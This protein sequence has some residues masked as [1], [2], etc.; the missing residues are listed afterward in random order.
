MG[1]YLDDDD[2]LR[3]MRDRFMQSDPGG[4]AM[5]GNAYGAPPRELNPA[6]V[7]SFLA[8]KPADDRGPYPIPQRESG[9][10][11]ADWFPLAAAGLDLAF[12]KGR[13]MGGIAQSAAGMAQ[14][15]D[16]LSQQQFEDDRN[17]YMKQGEAGARDRQIDLAGRNADMRQMEIDAQLAKEKAIQARWLGER[18]D[19]E[20]EKQAKEAL[21]R[22]SNARATQ[23]EADAARDPNAIT[24]YQQAQL[25]AQKSARQLTDE[26]RDAARAD[27]TTALKMQ[28]DERSEARTFR[29]GQTKRQNDVDAQARTQKLG[30][31]FA[32]QYEYELKALPALMTAQRLVDEV[33]QGGDIPG[34]GKWDSVK[35]SIPLIGAQLSSDKDLSMRSASEWMANIVQRAESGAAAPVPEALGYRIRQGSQPGATER[36]FKLGLAAA[37]EY[38]R[39]TLRAGSYGREDAARGVTDL[40]SRGGGDFVFGPVAQPPTNPTPIPEQ[41]S[42]APE[43]IRLGGQRGMPGGGNNFGFSGPPAGDA[44]PVTDQRPGQVPKVNDYLR[45]LSD[46]DDDLGVVYR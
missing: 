45:K 29:E 13:G 41:P 42:A 35:G 30:G 39:G 14:R 37:T 3:K 8:Q 26:D 46:E 2:E 11:I 25:D 23:A 43:P 32:K 21:I 15:R 44:L 36:E 9:V 4:A 20:L 5:S 27:R 19:P 16:A 38:L 34:A 10:G 22:L 6:A 31:E 40:Q 1:L 33:P 28:M 18:P 24:P 17:A 7:Q 12:N